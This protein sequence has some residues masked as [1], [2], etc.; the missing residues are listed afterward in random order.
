MENDMPR[1]NG[2]CGQPKITVHV[3]ILIGALLALT[4]CKTAKD[5]TT[6]KRLSYHPTEKVDHIDEYSGVKVADP[7]R[8]LE[9]DNSAATKAW[10]DSQN[11]VTFGYLEQIPER[12]PIRERLRKLWNFERYGTPFKEGH[13]YFYTKNNGLQNQSVLYTMRSLTDQPQV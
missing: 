8:W 10:V 3:L 5:Q 9:D 13:R 1:L 4:A 7:Y 2:D 11:K 12:G 6:V